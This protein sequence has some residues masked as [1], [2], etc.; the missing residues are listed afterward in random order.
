V[1]S[2]AINTM[3]K[4]YQ[5]SKICYAYLVD[6]DGVDESD[7]FLTQL[8]AARWFERGWTLQE[9][10]APLTVVFYSK[11]W[12]RIGT[13]LDKRNII[14]EITGID[15]GILQTGA[16]DHTS[17]AQKMSWAARR[18]TTKIEDMAYCLLGIFGVTMSL[19]YGEGKESFRR[20]QDGIISSSEDHS[21]YAWRDSRILQSVDTFWDNL[22]DVS[23][24]QK[25][26]I[27]SEGSGTI[28]RH[29]LLKGLLAESPADFESSGDVRWLESWSIEMATTVTIRQRYV[30]LE[31]PLIPLW[32][33][34]PTSMQVE[35]PYIHHGQIDVVILDCGLEKDPRHC[36]GVPVLRWNAQYHGKYHDPVLIPLN[37]LPD[38][39]WFS[40]STKRLNIGEERLS[41]HA[42][43][44]QHRDIYIPKV[45]ANLQYTLSHIFCLYPAMYLPT[46][47]VVR[48]GRHIRGIIASLVFSSDTKNEMVVHLSRG[49]PS[50]DDMYDTHDALRASITL[51]TNAAP[52]IKSARK[53]KRKRVSIQTLQCLFPSVIS[54]DNWI[55]LSVSSLVADLD[56]CSSS[57]KF[58]GC[59]QATS[60]RE[61]LLQLE[62]QYF[63]S[64]HL[65]YIPE[66]SNPPLFRSPVESLLLLDESFPN[67]QRVV[68]S[69]S[70]SESLHFEH[71]EDN[72]NALFKQGTAGMASHLSLDSM[73][74]P[75]AWNIVMD[76]DPTC[77]EISQMQRSFTK[78]GSAP[79][80]DS[81]TPID[82]LM[83]ID[84]L[85][86]SGRVRWEA[87]KAGIST[88][89]WLNGDSYLDSPVRY[90]ILH[91]LESSYFDWILYQN[92]IPEQVLR[93]LPLEFWGKEFMIAWNAD[94]P[95]YGG[96]WLSRTDSTSCS[97]EDISYNLSPY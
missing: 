85:I 54:H 20:L 33:L 45:V 74:Y 13:K 66:I 3:Y 51:N 97:P 11:T 14:S 15:V 52:K 30:Q 23:K 42:N 77:R 28:S 7:Q 59:V 35:F 48:P 47:S 17:I 90:W 92:Y 34:V 53:L 96:Y 29:Q 71:K 40:D 87:F 19:Q 16:L 26:T 18:T 38:D 56:P 88:R 49:Q 2:E 95:E 9:L 22:I 32:Q 41:I 1:L 21:I 81:L 55:D 61:K 5:R 68:Q 10:I 12:R 73:S 91:N 25:S 86:S 80:L 78:L 36:F 84:P 8:R 37:R 24:I 82:D 83:D 4:W 63:D 76:L 69:G 50:I 65:K 93:E 64:L 46:L 43:T 57:G 62:N 94:W 44:V 79:V 6:V 70:F 67:Q 27:S 89:F 31:L 58:G 39:N 75:E 72:K 60:S